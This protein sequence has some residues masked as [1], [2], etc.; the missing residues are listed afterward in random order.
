M[1]GADIDFMGDV[2]VWENRENNG[3]VRAEAMDKIQEI[4]PTLERKQP[5][6]QSDWCVLTKSHANGKIKLSTLKAQSTTT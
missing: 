4:N 1:N 6:D 2:L 3:M 5:K